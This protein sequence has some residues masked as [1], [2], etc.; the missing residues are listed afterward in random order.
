MTDDELETT[1]RIEQQPRFT[2]EEAKVLHKAP[3][4][5]L[6]ATPASLKARVL[7]GELA[8]RYP[9]PQSAKGK[10]YARK[11]TLVDHAHAVAAFVADL[12]A[13]VHSDRSEGWLRCSLKKE[14]YTGQNVTWRM[15]DAVRQAFTEAGLVEHLPGY[16]GAHGFGNP[17][18]S[19]GKL[20]RFRATPALLSACE[21]YGVTP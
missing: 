8:K 1:E 10:A 14:H 5:T 19:H 9:R 11:K 21:A 16:P 12:L 20:S 3:L 2:P 7:A 6:S 15:F 18:P 13:A 17:G 4:A